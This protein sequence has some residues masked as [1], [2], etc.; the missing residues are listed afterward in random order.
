MPNLQDVQRFFDAISAN[1]VE[2]N[3]GHC[4]YVLAPSSVLEVLL[5]LGYILC[6]CVVCSGVC[7]VFGCVRIH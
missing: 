2:K 5:H 6:V 7:G 4:N 3:N 1:W